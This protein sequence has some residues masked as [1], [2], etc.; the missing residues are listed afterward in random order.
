[1]ASNGLYMYGK[2][3]DHTENTLERQCYIIANDY[4]SFDWHF[5][6]FQYSKFKMCESSLFKGFS[7]AM[8]T[9]LNTNENNYFIKR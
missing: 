6:Q 7:C 2:K 4:I 1:M 8:N 5:E 3:R 9:F